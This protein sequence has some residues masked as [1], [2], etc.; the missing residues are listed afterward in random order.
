MP[1]ISDK[2]IM[3]N[4]KLKLN[5]NF[6]NGCNIIKI[7]NISNISVNKNKF[8]VGENKIDINNNI[9]NDYQKDDLSDEYDRVNLRTVSQDDYR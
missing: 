7:G 5:K 6:S 4:M 8:E 9:R 3:E 1:Y 2:K